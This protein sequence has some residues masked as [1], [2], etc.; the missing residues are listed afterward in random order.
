MEERKKKR[1]RWRMRRN[2]LEANPKGFRGDPRSQRRRIG[3]DRLRGRQRAHLG[4]G[5][6]S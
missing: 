4:D 5:T 3:T 1:E 6:R 2:G